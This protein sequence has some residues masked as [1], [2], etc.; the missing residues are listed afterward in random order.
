MDIETITKL[1]DAG[2]TKADIDAMEAGKGK[3]ETGAGDQQ[4][5]GKNDPPAGE[6]QG[7]DGAE[8][9]GKVEVPDPLEAIKALTA[10]VNGLNETVK[11][12]QAANVKNAA[13]ATSSKSD[14][15]LTAMESFI[16]TL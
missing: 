1:I 5:A 7:N 14:P 15:I 12:M 6:K 16:S 3:D 10:T 13:T 2:Y 4:N 9:A 8:N 11:A